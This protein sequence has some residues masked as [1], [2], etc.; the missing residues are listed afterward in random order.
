MTIRN[1]RGKATVLPFPSRPVKY[2]TADVQD[3]RT[4]LRCIERAIRILES[5]AA[6]SGPK[7]R[8]RRR[9]SV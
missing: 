5:L 8:D 7:A 1:R 6:K 9:A 2:S 3:L 4:E